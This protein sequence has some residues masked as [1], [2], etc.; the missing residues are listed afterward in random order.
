LSIFLA[1]QQ[2]RYPIRL[3]IVDGNDKSKHSAT[4][5]KSKLQSERPF[6]LCLRHFAGYFYLKTTW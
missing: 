5:L 4:R 6:V 2:I 1:A 3:I